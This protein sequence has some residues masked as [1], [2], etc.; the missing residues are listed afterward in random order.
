MT[1]RA[2]TIDDVKAI[3]NRDLGKCDAAQL[4]VFREYSVEPYF[5]PLERFGDTENVVVVARKS[6]EVMYWEDVEEGFNISP[7]ASDG[8]IL[9]HGSNQ[10]NLGWALNR[11][12][13]GRRNHSP[14]LPHP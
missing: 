12:I 6:S 7:V 5:A 14:F 11:W 3:L 10:D 1:W 8:R 13:E 4:E 9:E 2:A